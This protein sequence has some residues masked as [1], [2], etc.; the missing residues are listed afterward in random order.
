MK[1]DI[2]LN[3]CFFGIFTIGC[4]GFGLLLK[5]SIINY[6]FYVAIV[7][8]SNIILYYFNKWIRRYLNSNQ[9]PDNM[10]YRRNIQRN[11]D[12]ILLGNSIAKENIRFADLGLSGFD[13][14]LKNQTLIYDF[15]VL[16]QFF[17]ILKT[18]GVVLFPLSIIDIDKWLFP[19]IDKRPYYFNF[20]GFSISINKHF[21]FLVKILKRLPILMTR[22]SDIVWFLKSRFKKPIDIEINQI[23]KKLGK[24]KDIDLSQIERVIN[25]IGTFC[26]IRNIIPIFILLPVSKHIEFQTNIP[27]QLEDWC[28]R[29]AIHCYNYCD[30]SKYIS[31]N[32]YLEDGIRFNKQGVKAFNMELKSIINNIN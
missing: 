8:I 21:L 29:N 3:I 24:H 31:E 2:L 19:P 20:F 10:W 14:S 26:K 1:K 5:L 18:N 16:K 17:S 32:L 22:P 25:E 27:K 28:I 6:I 4:L 23:V 13:L 15:H 12:I 11:M 30:N 7:I 9:Y